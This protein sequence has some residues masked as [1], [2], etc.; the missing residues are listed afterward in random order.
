LSVFFKHHRGEVE[1]EPTEKQALRDFKGLEHGKHDGKLVIENIS[2]KMSGGVHKVVDEKFTDS[3][4]FKD[5][6][7]GEVKE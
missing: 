7:E 1:G 4:Q 6:I 3:A 5:T 2:P